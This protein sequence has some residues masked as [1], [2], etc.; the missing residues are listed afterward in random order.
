VVDAAMHVFW[1]Q[2]YGA[3]SVQDLVDAT[4]VQRG[5]LYGA[6]GDKHGLLLEALDTYAEQPFQ[7]LDQLLRES[8][9]PVDAI[10]QFIRLAGIDSRDMESASRGCL[11]GNTCAELASHDEAA[12]LRVESFVG[13]LRLAMADALRSAQEMGTFDRNRDPEAVAM[14]VQCSL[15]GLAVLAKSGPDPRVIDSLI[16][17]VLR[18]FDI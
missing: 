12:R 3:T 1:R 14:F 17:E 13:R 9:D 15:Q 4:G 8:E 2:G 16:N 18:I 5:S 11:M 6:F 10:R 7:R